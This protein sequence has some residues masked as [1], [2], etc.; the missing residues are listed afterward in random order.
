MQGVT[1]VGP[2]NEIKV[3]DL[4]SGIGGIALGLHRAGP[5]KTE[6]F[7]E[8]D[9]FCQQILRHHWPDTRI[10]DDV[11]TLD[12]GTLGKIDL[13]CGGFPCQDI[14]FAGGGEGLEGD[15]SGLWREFRRI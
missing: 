14:S 6:C 15:R 2:I 11:C 4:F 13:V 3:L 7:V 12:T 9:P 10:H 1:E 5:F 8:N